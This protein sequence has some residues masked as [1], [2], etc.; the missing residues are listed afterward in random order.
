MTYT[1]SSG[2]LNSSIP[3]HGACETHCVIMR[4]CVC[5]GTSFQEDNSVHLPGGCH[6]TWSADGASR[7]CWIDWQLST[8]QPV[9]TWLHRATDQHQPSMSIHPPSDHSRCVTLW[10]ISLQW[11][12]TLSNFDPLVSSTVRVLKICQ[13]LAKLW[14]RVGC[15]GSVDWRGW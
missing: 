8:H 15:P 7:R 9:M 13:H 5:V 11:L 1:V 14:A 6:H 12:H 10:N 3:Y 2:T 4:V